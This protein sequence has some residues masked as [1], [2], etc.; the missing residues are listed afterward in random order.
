MPAMHCAVSPK[1]VRAPAIRVT[2]N[3]GCMAMSINKNDRPPA[4]VKRINRV[5]LEEPLAF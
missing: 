2:F 3:M 5:R 4:I 1:V